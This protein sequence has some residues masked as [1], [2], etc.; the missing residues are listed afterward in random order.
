[1]LSAMSELFCLC[2]GFGTACR[3]VGFAPAKDPVG[4]G[5]LEGAG[6]S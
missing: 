5:G 2:G 4:C 3:A 6:D 1:M